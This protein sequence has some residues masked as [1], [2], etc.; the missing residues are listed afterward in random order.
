MVTKMFEQ[1]AWRTQFEL[2]VAGCDN[3]TTKESM[4][5]KATEIFFRSGLE[6]LPRIKDQQNGWCIQL[7]NQRSEESLV[8]PT[9]QR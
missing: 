8:L 1:S 5:A 2:R 7:V 9:R 6:S 3:R 4:N